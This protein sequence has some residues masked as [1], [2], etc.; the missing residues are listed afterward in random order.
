ME[1]PSPAPMTSKEETE[2]QEGTNIPCPNLGH[3]PLMPHDVWLPAHP[4]PLCNYRPIQLAKVSEQ[5]GTL[6]SSGRTESLTR[7]RLWMCLAIPTSSWG[8]K[9]VGGRA[10][11][12]FRCRKGWELDIN[13][14]PA[15]GWGGRAGFRLRM[16]GAGSLWVVGQIRYLLRQGTDP[17][18]DLMAQPSQRTLQLGMQCVL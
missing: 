12:E 18:A 11:P 1:Y 5:G 13:P 7:T 15:G 14:S 6:T 3:S 17:A 8:H 2:A 4:E 10:G 9:T 16:G